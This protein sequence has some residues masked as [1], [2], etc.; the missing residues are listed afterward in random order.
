MKFILR[1]S[2]GHTFYPSPPE[3]RI[4]CDKAMEWHDRERERAHRQDQMRQDRPAPRPEPSAAERER[5]SRIYADFCRGYEKAEAEETFKL[6]PE[7]VAQ[8]ADNPKAQI[9][10]RRGKAA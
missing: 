5:V 10:Q 1:G 4:Q 3:L 8:V 6:D 2:L 9:H 7:L